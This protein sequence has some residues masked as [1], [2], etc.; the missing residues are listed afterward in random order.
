MET[1]AESNL[2]L[3]EHHFSAINYAVFGG[4]LALSALIGVYFGFVSKKKQNNTIEYLLGGRTM[5]YF[6]IGFSLITSQISGTTLLAVPAEIYAFGSE[7]VWSV[8]SSVL[9]RTRDQKT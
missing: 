9:V 5:S 4:M 3:L 7:Y 2:T 8:F 1:I 6:P